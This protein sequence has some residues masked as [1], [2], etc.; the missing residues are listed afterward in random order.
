LTDAL[1]ALPASVLA[2][3]DVPVLS[4]VRD[5]TATPPTVTAEAPVK[6]VPLITIVVPPE[7][8]PLAGVVPLGINT[9]VTIGTGIYVYN[10]L[11]TE[12]PP[13][14]VTLTDTSPV[15]PEGAFA[16]IVVPLLVTEMFVA[17][18]LPTVTCVAPV[19][20]VPVMVI[21]APA[22]SGPL[23]GDTLVTVGAATWTNEPAD[24]V[25]PGVV[26]II[27]DGPTSSAGVDTVTDSG[28][29][30]TMFVSIPLNVTLLVPDRY[31]P[32]NITCVFPLSGPDGGSKELIVGAF[33]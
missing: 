13:G 27:M 6:P 9:P 8:G 29:T 15:V 16:V 18:L 10:A 33:I 20:P 4:T 12:V 32:V 21:E 26:S 24:T 2:V 22:V 11:S 28:K 23:A 5:V 17:A 3:I 7:S 31:E 19:K 30:D 25:P 14:V 1:P